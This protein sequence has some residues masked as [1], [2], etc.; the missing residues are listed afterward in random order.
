MARWRGHPTTE[1]IPR[2]RILPYHRSDPRAYIIPPHPAFLGASSRP[3]LFPFSHVG[4]ADERRAG[5]PTDRD[6]G[7]GVPA[8]AVGDLKS[9]PSH[10]I[11]LRVFGDYAHSGLLPSCPALLC[12]LRR[13]RSKRA[14]GRRDRRGR[15]CGSGS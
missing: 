4:G 1:V 14:A 3:S 10:A 2:R 13:A 7:G 12:C 8:G 5:A 11:V 9:G 6:A 15:L